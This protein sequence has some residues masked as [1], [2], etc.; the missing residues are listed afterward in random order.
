MV[1]RT[2]FNCCKSYP[3]PNLGIADSADYEMESNHLGYPAIHCRACG[4]YPPLVDD[5]AVANVLKEK[6]AVNFSQPLTGCPHCT[7]MFFELNHAVSRQAIAAKRYG[8]TSAGQQRLK[9]RHCSHVY[10]LKAIK[11]GHRLEQLLQLIAQNTSTTDTI[12]TLNCAPK[13]Y[14]QLLA[15]LADILRTYS[16]LNEQVFMQRNFLALHTESGVIHY[17][18]NKSVWSLATTEAQSGYCLLYNHNLQLSEPSLTA[19]NGE[20][21][22][23]LPSPMVPSILAALTSRYQST[24]R[25]PHFEAL[26]Y[27][28]VAN[29]RGAD[30]VKP[31]TLAY[32]HFQLLRIFSEQSQHFHHYI[33]HESAIRGAALMASS[34]EIVDEKAEVFFVYRH[35]TGGKELPSNGNNIGWWSDRWYGTH[36]GAYC[37]ITY[38]S[39]YQVPFSLFDAEGPKNY[40]RWIKS[41]QP[42]SLKSA[43]SLDAMLEIQ[44]NIYNFC[45]PLKTGETPAMRLSFCKQPYTLNQLLVVA[46]ASVERGE[47]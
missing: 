37:P 22:S 12:T 25:R 13:I 10:T 9:C 46:I 15:K 5:L 34:K 44:R 2:S 23:I 29:L 47:L 8:H 11:Q 3:C 16:R 21:S 1:F 35:F 31:S 38:R 26:H 40:H 18:G 19:Y 20:N 4:S 28:Q 17:A 42:D 43:K 45:Q 39:K 6:L 24:M 27:G 14:Y 33:E 7:D 36:Y 41:K 30:Y 32:A